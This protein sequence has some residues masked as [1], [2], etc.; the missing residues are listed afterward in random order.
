MH[1]LPPQNNTFNV[2]PIVL[3]SVSLC[4]AL[5]KTK[6]GRKLMFIGSRSQIFNKTSTSKYLKNLVLVKKFSKLDQNLKKLTQK[7]FASKIWPFI[8]QTEYWSEIY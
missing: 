2:C 4:I 3:K 8:K 7:R 6:F 5:F 1:S